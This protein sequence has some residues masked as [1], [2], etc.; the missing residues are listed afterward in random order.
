L[1][2][3]TKRGN[4]P[5][6]HEELNKALHAMAAHLHRYLSELKSLEETLSDIGGYYESTGL[7]GPQNPTIENSIWQI[8]SQLQP[9][10]HFASEL[11]KKLQ[12][13]LALVRPHAIQCPYEKLTY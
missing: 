6:F 5:T 12:N 4:D 13:I 10:K 11:E 2:D 8:A 1:Q 7:Q 9:I 3:D